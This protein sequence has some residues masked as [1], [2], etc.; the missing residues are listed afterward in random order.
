MRCEQN[1]IH[2]VHI[3]TGTADPTTVTMK[4]IYRQPWRF[5]REIAQIIVD[6]YRRKNRHLNPQTLTHFQLT[7]ILLL[8][9]KRTYGCIKYVWFKSRFLH[10]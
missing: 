4:R 5:Q 2:T 8:L 9:T 10:H 6:L 1:F 3:D 7:G